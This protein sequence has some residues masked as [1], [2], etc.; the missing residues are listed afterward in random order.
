MQ[1]QEAVAVQDDQEHVQGV[2]V[3]HQQCVVGE[4]ALLSGARGAQLAQGAGGGGH[5]GDGEGA[6]VE[7]GDDGGPQAQATTFMS[8]RHPED[9]VSPGYVKYRRRRK[10]D[11]LVQKQI[12]SKL[13]FYK[14]QIVPS[15]GLNSGSSG[16]PCVAMERERG[17]KR[18]LDQMEGPVARKKS[19]E[20]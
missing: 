6:R 10:P 5:D 20:D 13:V 18:G 1:H 7:G 2:G 14:E 11:G 3:D 4:D 17:L 16:G 9:G 19:R 8:L 15:V 12:N